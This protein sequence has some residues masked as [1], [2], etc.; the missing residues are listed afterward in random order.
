MRSRSVAGLTAAFLLTRAA[1]LWA[2]PAPGPLQSSG[3]RPPTTPSSPP[4][5]SPSASTRRAPST[6]RRSPSPSPGRRSRR[7]SSFPSRRAPTG[8]SPRRRRSSRWRSRTAP[9]PPATGGSVTPTFDAAGVFTVRL[10]AT[11][12]RQLAASGLSAGNL[13]TANRTSSPATHA[14]HP[15]AHRRDF[16]AGG[17]S[18]PIASVAVA[19]TLAGSTSAASPPAR[20]TTSVRHGAFGASTP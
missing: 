18:T 1:A 2:L 6:P 17:G 4:A 20:A 8:G 15:P 7:R 14:R 9:S 16:G 19:S 3:R 11:L 12:T 10:G 13:V 5:P